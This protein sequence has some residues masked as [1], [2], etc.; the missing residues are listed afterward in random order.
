MAK[1]AL[2]VVAV[3]VEDDAQTRRVEERISVALRQE[4]LTPVPC[5]WAPDRDT[6]AEGLYAE[7]DDVEIVDMNP[8][9]R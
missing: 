5:D 2:V 3:K 9:R 1:Y 6:V 7:F 8:S 4:G